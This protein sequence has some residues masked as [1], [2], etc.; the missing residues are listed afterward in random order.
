MYAGRDH[1]VQYKSAYR[2]DISAT[3]TALHFD[4]LYIHVPLLRFQSAAGENNDN[5]E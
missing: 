2:I 3:A 1:K 5:A 4:K